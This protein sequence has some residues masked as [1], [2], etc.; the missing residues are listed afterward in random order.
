MTIKTK[1]IANVLLTVAIIGAIS[2][3]SYFSMSFLQEKL[4]YLTEKSS[5]FQMRTVEFQREL[6]GCITNLIK[7]NA[8]RTMTEYTT[9][10]AEAERSLANVRTAQELLEKMSGGTSRLTVSAEMRPLADELF[11]AALVRIKSDSAASEAN[12]R[13]SQQMKDSSARLKNLDIHIRN[14]QVTR[15]AAFSRALENTNRISAGLRELEELRIQVNDLKAASSAAHNVRNYTAFLIAQGKIK[16]ILWRIARNRSADSISFDRKEL[17]DD[18]GEFLYLQADALSKKDVA[19]IKWALDSFDELSELLNRTNLT[20][21]QDIELASSKLIIETNRQGIIFAQSNSANGIL[22]TNS[23]LVALGLT[24]TGDLNRLFMLG[25]SAEVDSVAAE[26]RSN[27]ATIQE[28]ARLVKGSLAKLDAKDELK[29][30][31]AAVAS[32]AAIRSELYSAGGIIATL[33]QKLDAI[34]QADVSADKLHATVLKQLAQGKESVSVAQGEQ[35]KSIGAVNR[36]VSRSLSQIAGISCVAIVIGIFFG[37]WIYRSI[38]QPL[39][40]ILAAVS[41][42]QK[43]GQEQASLAEAVA[44]GDLNREVLIS[45]PITLDSAQIEHNEMGTVLNAVVEMSEAQVT[46][47]RAFAGMTAALRKSRDEDERRDRLKS[48]LF[49]LNKILRGDHTIADL[50]DESLFFLA[51][52]LGAGAGIMYLHNERDG[53]LQTLSTYAISRSKRLNDGFLLGEGLPGRVALERKMLC[54]T[55]VPS[56][57]LPIASA[58][59]AADPLNIAILPF[60]HNETLVGVVELGSFRQFGAVDFEFLTQS[61][62]GIAIAIN[63]NRS[64]QLVNELLEQSQSQAEELRVQQEELEQ[65]N[66]ELGERARMLTEQRRKIAESP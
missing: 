60:M 36:M 12:A 43:Q 2:L 7:V 34:K 49:E 59:G 27:F 32:L 42:Q 6:Q 41:S 37:F 33:K 53:M 62:E 56:D 5:P 64:H 29:M 44:A 19:S 47:D 66:E 9:I 24:V 22:L 23:E 45:N 39:R 58:L 21:N 4:S 28:R 8:A 52:F 51:E 61:L 48:G 17:I 63:V 35:E 40:V 3:T 31:H 10:H 11:T 16:T 57:Y 46:L 55:A 13:V 25:S 30:L 65:T 50:G 1:L 15:S 26:I 20:L 18:I 14:L 38:L 54:L